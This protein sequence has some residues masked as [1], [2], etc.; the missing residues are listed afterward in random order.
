MFF[1]AAGHIVQFQLHGSSQEKTDRLPQEAIWFSLF[2][3][4][5]ACGLHYADRS[6]RF[7][8]ATPHNRC[9]LFKDKG[10]LVSYT[11]HRAAETGG[12][13]RRTMDQ[14]SLGTLAQKRSIS[15]VFLCL[16]YYNTVSAKINTARYS[17][18]FCLLQ[19]NHCNE[20]DLDLR[21][22]PEKILTA[23]PGYVIIAKLQQADSS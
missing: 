17:F 10:Y 16:F 7:L 22:R 2:C 8:L 14:F 5:A 1:V 23:H 18:L 3:S 21:A 13:D 9:C 6:F 19:P 4:S 20:Y 11:P 12:T 15:F